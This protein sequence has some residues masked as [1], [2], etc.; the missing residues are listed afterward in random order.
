MKEIVHCIG[1]YTLRLLCLSVILVG[2]YY[3][4]DPMRK[5]INDKA[6]KYRAEAN[7]NMQRALAERLKSK[8]INARNKF[9]EADEQSLLGAIFELAT[10]DKGRMDSIS[11]A[12]RDGLIT[13]DIY[14]NMLRS[15][16][17]E[18]PNS[19]EVKSLLQLEALGEAGRQQV[20]DLYRQ[21]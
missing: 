6:N 8:Y 16:A 14:M 18:D 20:I 13:P 7:A 10:D 11:T 15:M 3:L 1:R 9:P 19:F 21:R 4:R 17:A 12:I 2:M 5:F